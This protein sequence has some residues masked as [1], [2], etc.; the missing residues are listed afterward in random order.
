MSKGQRLTEHDALASQFVEAGISLLAEQ[1]REVLLRGL[2]SEDVVH[3]AGASQATFFRRFTTK[4]EFVDALVSR[5]TE[6]GWPT[7][8]AV[9]DA[10]RLSRRTHAE[11]VNP[12]VVS[13]AADT[14]NV[15]VNDALSART[16]LAQAFGS[17]R[18]L[19]ADYGRRDELV[20]AAYEAL[21][22]QADATMRRPF[23]VRTLG[24]TVNAMLDGFRL[25]SRVDPA[26]VSAAGVADA[27]LA[28]LG[29]VVDT[30]GRHQHLDDVVA[31]V[32]PV[33]TRPRPRDPRA[34]IIDAARIEFGKRGYFMTRI[35]DIAD[36][37]AVPRAAVKKLFPTKQHILVGALQ[38]R[39]DLL[40]ETVADDLLIGTDEV[41]II[42][43]FLLRCARLAAHEIEFMDAMLVAVAHDTYGEPDGLLSIK[44][45][46]NIPSIIGPVIQ[47]GQD[48]GTLALIGSPVDL[49]AGITNTLLMRCFTR[50]NNTPEDNAKFIADLLLRGLGG[51]P[52]QSI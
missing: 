2:R 45:K 14:F 48:S 24:M 1:P 51:Q 3:R 31:P 19:K 44:Q 47:Q 22:E 7:A 37:A 52:H 11:A 8:E 36:D 6:S 21:F 43:N 26:A 28:F 5:L 38:A 17:K 25:R 10:V 40:R 46:L 30:S 49:A 39:V 34:A 9:R 29:A 41:T 13:L 27:V 18:A 12:A 16:V 35:D 32:E 42:E 15:L 4:S 33:V 20:V 50:R 23:T